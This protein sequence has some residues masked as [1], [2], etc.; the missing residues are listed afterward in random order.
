MC[1]ILNVIKLNYQNL[2]LYYCYTE[3]FKLNCILLNNRYQKGY[4][5]INIAIG[6]NFCIFSGLNTIKIVLL[7]N[8]KTCERD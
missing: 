3:K 6:M 4:F 5:G 1:E 8:Y 7:A 2:F